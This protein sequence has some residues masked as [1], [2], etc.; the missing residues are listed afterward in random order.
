MVGE[1]TEDKTEW[2]SDTEMTTMLQHFTPH[3]L[4]RNPTEDLL[5]YMAYDTP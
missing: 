1:Y 5:R 4:A 2:L 3:A